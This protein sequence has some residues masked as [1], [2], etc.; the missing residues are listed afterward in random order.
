MRNLVIDFDVIVLWPS[1]AFAL[2]VLATSIRTYLSPSVGYWEAK[3][4]GEEHLDEWRRREKREVKDLLWLSGGVLL[5]LCAV[6]LTND[7]WKMN[8]AYLVWKPLQLVSAVSLVIAAL[9]AWHYAERRERLKLLACLLVMLLAA[10]STEHF[11]H[12]AINTRHV[13]CPHCGD[14]DDQNN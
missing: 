13:V 7:K 6:M 1:I 10:A 4:R 12:Q 9:A 2:I 3:E 5:V 11:F 14:D 8:F